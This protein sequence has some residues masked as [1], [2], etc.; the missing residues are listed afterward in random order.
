MLFSPKIKFELQNCVSYS[1]DKK[2]ADLIGTKIGI[3]IHSTKLSSPPLVLS[4]F[5][6]G[7]QR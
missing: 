4:R 2:A 5:E 6:I 1:S 7:L 3:D